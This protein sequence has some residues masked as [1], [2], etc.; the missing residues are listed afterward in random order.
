MMNNF[1]EFVAALHVEGMTGPRNDHNLGM[2]ELL[3]HEIGVFPWHQDVL[4]S[5]HEKCWC[6][7][8]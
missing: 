5:S 7:D 6:L 3:R 4:A 1:I 2:G 8:P